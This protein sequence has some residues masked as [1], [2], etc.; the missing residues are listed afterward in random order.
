MISEQSITSLQYHLTTV[1][2]H[3]S[4]SSLQYHLTTV[5]PHY[6]FTSPQYLLTTVSPHYS[7][8]SLQYHLTTVSPHHSITSLQYHLTTVSPHYS[9]ISLQYHLTTVSP[10]YN[11]ISCLYYNTIQLYYMYFLRQLV[12]TRKKIKDLLIFVPKKRIL[13]TCTQSC[14]DW[15][16]RGGSVQIFTAYTFVPWVFME[17]EHQHA[18]S[19]RYDPCK[20]INTYPSFRITKWK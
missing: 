17:L 13:H 16:L 3:H 19:A 8:T 20:I 5:S 7:I 4:I 18:N 12:L 11:I 10:H 15:E 6:S 14:I 2:P 1:S 9:I